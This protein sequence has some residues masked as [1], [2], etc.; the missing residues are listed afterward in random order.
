MNIHEMF[1][2]KLDAAVSAMP[3]EVSSGPSSHTGH[4]PDNAIEHIQSSCYSH[5]VKAPL[6][7]RAFACGI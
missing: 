4:P 2:E 5:A 3:P 1:C 6:S 7:F